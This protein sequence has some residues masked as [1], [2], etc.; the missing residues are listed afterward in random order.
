[1]ENIAELGKEPDSE[2]TVLSPTATVI[3]D[4]DATG[5]KEKN[6]THKNRENR[7]SSAVETAMFAAKGKK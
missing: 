1:V 6:A 5:T 4:A 7:V 3:P 2:K